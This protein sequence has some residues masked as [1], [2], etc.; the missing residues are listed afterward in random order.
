MNLD[1]SISAPCHHQRLATCRGIY[2]W[3]GT[4]NRDCDAGWLSIL[5]HGVPFCFVV[6]WVKT[7]RTCGWTPARNAMQRAMLSDFFICDAFI[8]WFSWSLVTSNNPSFGIFLLDG[9]SKHHKVMCYADRTLF[10]SKQLFVGNGRLIMIKPPMSELV[11]HKLQS[12]TSIVSAIH[13][14]NWWRFVIMDLSWS[15]I[16]SGSV[17]R[18]WIQWFVINQV[19]YKSRFTLINQYHPSFIS[20]LLR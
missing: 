7:C 17:G 3:A 9:K 14:T 19:C 16:F 15:L 8:L 18:I 20:F 5:C 4:R 13:D 11:I 6:S 1:P 2:A 10:C 12:I